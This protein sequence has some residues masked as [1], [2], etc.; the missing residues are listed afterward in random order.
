MS[1]T[2]TITLQEEVDGVLKR[3]A[4]EITAKGGS[5]HGNAEQGLF[6]GH[7][8]LGSIKG[9]YRLLS[10]TEVSITIKSKPFIVPYG[11]IEAEIRQ[12]FG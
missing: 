5:F 2:F 4:S 10:D 12:Y 11:T 8:V 7:S 6:A 9:E 1:H 3:V